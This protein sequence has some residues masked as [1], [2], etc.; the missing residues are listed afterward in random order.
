MKRPSILFGN[1]CIYES[2]L[3]EAINNCEVLLS[4]NAVLHRDKMQKYLTILK[5]IK[6][7]AL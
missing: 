3:L 6:D 1:S 2:S 5:N 7:K 4:H